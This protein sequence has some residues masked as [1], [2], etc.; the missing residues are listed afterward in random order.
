MV[1]RGGM[2]TIR[3]DQ[4]VEID[5]NL[6]VAA[7]GGLGVT[8]DFEPGFVAFKIGASEFVIEENLNVGHG[9]CF[10]EK[11]LIEFASIDC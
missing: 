3:T 8:H 6:V 2:C 9:F 10:V 7:S 1:P 5:F 11:D 4:E